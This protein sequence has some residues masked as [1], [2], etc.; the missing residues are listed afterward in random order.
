MESRYDR[1]EIIGGIRV[2]GAETNE[3][4]SVVIMS[5]YPN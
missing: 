1:A 2:I 5:D 4:D 3:G